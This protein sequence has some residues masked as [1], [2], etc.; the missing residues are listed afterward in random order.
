[1]LLTIDISNSLITL[2]GYRRT[3]E[4]FEDTPSFMARFVTEP[5]RTD[6]QYAV[7]IRQLLELYEVPVKKIQDVMIASV[8]PEINAAFARAIQKVLGK[9]AL[10]VGPG[11]KTG[12][13]IRMDTPSQLGADLVAGAVAAVESYPLPCIIFDLGTATTISVVDRQAQF[14]GG[15]ICP[16]LALN[17]QALA[18]KTA[19]LPHISI[20]KPSAVIGT[21][22]IHCMQS[23]AVYGT[24]AMLDGVAARIEQEL[25]DTATLIATGS[26][27]EIVVP[28]C[29]RQIHVCEHLLLNGL[30]SIY[31]KQKTAR[32]REGKA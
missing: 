1:M 8:V 18:S 19:L 17:L 3:G 12:L 28:A 13:N 16:G 20:E 25:G 14:R 24:A 29:Q 7:Q 2:G 15:M 5:S 30:K 22:T 26:L 6:D 23:G 21:N 9:H 27:A 11:S 31:R 4:D 32:Q 10:F